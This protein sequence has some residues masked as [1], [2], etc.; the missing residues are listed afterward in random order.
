MVLPRTALSGN[1]DLSFCLAE[2][3]SCGYATLH[4]DILACR[5]VNSGSARLEVHAC[6]L[7]FSKTVSRH[8]LSRKHTE[9]VT[10]QCVQCSK[11]SAQCN[12]SCRQW[13]VSCN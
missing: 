7:H 12:G 1:R 5:L 11:P 9:S 3:Q 4:E 13:H 10:E 2:A 8:M 6:P